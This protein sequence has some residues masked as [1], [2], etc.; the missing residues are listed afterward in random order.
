LGIR[1]GQLRK[2]TA[3]NETYILDSVNKS[4]RISYKDFATSFAQD[5]QVNVTDV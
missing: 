4:Q 1:S 5:M 3:R 2:L